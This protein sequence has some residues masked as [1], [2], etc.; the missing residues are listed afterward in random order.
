MI[1]TD[2]KTNKVSQPMI[3]ITYY[4]KSKK[5]NKSSLDVRRGMLLEEEDK[6]I[7]KIME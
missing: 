7:K 4:N 1:K 5:Q 2:I 6:A 3:I